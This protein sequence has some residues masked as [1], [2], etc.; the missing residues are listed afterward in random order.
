MDVALQEIEEK[1]FEEIP[2][3]CMKFHQFNI[4]THN[5]TVCYTI[6]K[7]L[8]DSDPFSILSM[9]QKECAKWK[10]ITCMKIHGTLLDMT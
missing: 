6:T 7:D 10:E 9:C 5:F 3:T 8:S 1:I 2:I 4:T